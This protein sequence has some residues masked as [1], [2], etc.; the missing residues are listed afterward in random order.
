MT[1]YFIEPRARKYVKGYGFLSVARNFSNKYRKQLLDI[2]L[3]A[4]KTASKNIVHKATEATGEF[5][6]NKIAGTAT[7]SDDNKTVKTKPVEEIIIPPE[8]RGEI[9]N[10]LR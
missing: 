8:K 3:D 1:R 10:E 9:L 6:G 5:L 4:L 2:E 7:N